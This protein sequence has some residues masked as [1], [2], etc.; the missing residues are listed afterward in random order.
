MPALCPPS[1]S[2]LQQ[3]VFDLDVVQF[4]LLYLSRDWSGQ[5]VMM[6]QD[7]GQTRKHWLRRKR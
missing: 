1:D 6:C 2:Y 4:I 3:A 7:V 5:V